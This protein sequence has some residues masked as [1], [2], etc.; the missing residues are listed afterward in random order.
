MGT[1]L[2]HHFAAEWQWFMAPHHAFGTQLRALQTRFCSDHYRAGL[3][4]NIQ[5]ELLRRATSEP[6]AAPL[7]DGHHLDGLDTAEFGT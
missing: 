6:Q 2:H 5:D 3:D 7:P 1:G 4:I